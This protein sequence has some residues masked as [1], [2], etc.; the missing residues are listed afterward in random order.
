VTIQVTFDDQFLGLTTTSDGTFNFVFDVPHAQVGS[1]EIHAYAEL[2]PFPVK[3]TANFTVVP[4]PGRLAVNISVGTVYFP[5]DTSTIYL[6]TTSNGN[7]TPSTIHLTLILPN[8]T[9]TDLSLQLVTPGLYKASYK[10]PTNGSLGTYALTATV[11]QNGLRASNLG[12]FEVKPSWLQAHGQA[13][14]TGSSIAGALGLVGVIAVAWRGGYLTKR[15]T[16]P[17]PEKQS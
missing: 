4:E 9:A 3:A 1:H 16:D 12:A 8:G 17:R 14:L 7:P 6:L 5:G 11:Q 2:Y 15:R 13:I 10:I